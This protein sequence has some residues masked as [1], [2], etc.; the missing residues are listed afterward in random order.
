MIAAVV[1]VVAVLV[2]DISRFFTVVTVVNA[3][4]LVARL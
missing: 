4:L 3:A 2:A 1:I